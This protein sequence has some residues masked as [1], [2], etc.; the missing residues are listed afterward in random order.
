MDPIP[1]PETLTIFTVIKQSGMTFAY[2]GM[3]TSQTIGVGFFLNQLEAEHHRT[4][5]ALRDPMSR[6]HIFALKVP[7]PTF[8]DN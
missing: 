1:T 8:K 7:N 4:L 2:T 6:Y 3:S 5:E